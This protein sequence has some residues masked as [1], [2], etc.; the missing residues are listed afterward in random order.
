MRKTCPYRRPPARVHRGRKNVEA[1]ESQTQRGNNSNFN[2]DAAA[3]TERHISMFA[4][5]HERR[6]Y[7]I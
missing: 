2:R 7:G 4:V 5:T 3:V 6:Q 1:N